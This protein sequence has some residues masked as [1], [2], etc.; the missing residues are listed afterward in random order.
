MAR[1]SLSLLGSVQV[2]LD[3]QPASGFV[4]NKARALL[5]YLAIEA[6]RPHQRNELATLSWPELPD[7]AARSNLRQAVANLREVIG[8]E[9]AATPFLLIARDTIQF[10]LA[11]PHRLDVA[12]FTALLAA[13]AHHCHRH[14]ARCRS[15]AARLEQVATLYRGD[16]LAGFVLGD[17]APFD[18]WQLRERERLHQQ[19]ITALV[20]LAEYHERRGDNECA[21]S[22]SQ[23]QIELDPWREEAHRQLMR[24]LARDG[25]R[26][27]ALA[28]YETCRSVLARDLGV[29]P[30]AETSVLYEQ[31]R[32]QEQVQGSSSPYLR[33]SMSS[34]HTFPAQP[35]A[36]VGRAAELSELSA[37]L[38][39]PACRLITVFG[40]GGM[41]KTRL[42][43]A[44]ASEQ[45][46]TFDAGVTFVPLAGINSA[47]LLASQILSALG[48]E[49]QDQRDPR[50]LLLDYLQLKELLL[51]LDNL[52]Q[53]LAP[54]ADQ[55]TTAALLA[56]IIARAPG[57]TLL[58]TSRERVALSGEWLFEL[59]GLSYPAGEL[60]QAA[61]R[62]DAMQL[63]AQRATQLRRHFSLEGEA[64]AVARI[65]RQVEGLPLAIE[66]SA[67]AVLVRSCAAIADAIDQNLLALAAE[68]R[69]VPERQRSIWATFEHSWRLLSEPEQQ[70]FAQLSVFRGGFDEDAAAAVALASPQR[71]A[72][73]VNKSL[74]RRYD[75]GRYD[76][77]ELLRQYAGEKLEQSGETEQTCWRHLVHFL[78]LAEAAEPHLVQPDQMTWMD[79]LETD[80]NNLR[81]ALA[82]CQSAND[83]QSADALLRLAAALWLFWEMHGHLQEGIGWLTTAL[84]AAP[85]DDTST[86][87][88]AWLSCTGHCRVPYRIHAAGTPRAQALIGIGHL[89]R[90]RGDYGRALLV[91]EQSL[92][93]CRASGDQWGC[94][95]SLHLLGRTVRDQGDYERAAPLLE[96]CLALYRRLGNNQAIAY[97]ICTLAIL[98]A[99]QGQDVR[100]VA[101]NEEGLAL[102][103]EVRDTRGTAVALQNLGG[104]A[105][106]H[107]EYERASLLFQQS[108]ALFNECHDRPMGADVLTSLGIVE[109][110]Q[111][112]YG[113]ARAYYQASLT[114]KETIGAT[115]GMATLVEKLAN[116]VRLSAAEE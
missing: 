39:N 80:H 82:W 63:F 62:Y 15:C 52:E 110:L 20:R 96:E 61:E 51:V 6:D 85:E 40:P 73:L 64:Q 9:R 93:L 113:S 34:R 83:S 38:E 49:L 58:V 76:L 57:V 94:A 41:G 29:E 100:A 54:E 71:L 28:Q 72:A 77:H 104:L 87:V 98:A 45:A 109:E 69:A 111:A 84:A 14:P 18:E 35:T 107:A 24:L 3:G 114:L 2:L 116:V 86:E 92:A 5:A 7:A 105:L 88:G 22:F 106:S 16:F 13:C 32:D 75:T 90:R 50:D 60:E 48:V 12:D 115:R 74:L 59:T 46:E 11:S 47:T 99:R 108:L 66:L 78:A 103:R 112:D 43:L 23:R 1:L 26:S 79:R 19:V 53:L 33:V 31:I 56:D 25:Q 70:T 44:V 42:A 27:A 68:V 101:L 89:V 8:N 81:A 67:A 21:R 95:A 55:E 97:A 102:F 30:E 10:N 36:L 17:S 37:L 4:Y 91:A 65:C